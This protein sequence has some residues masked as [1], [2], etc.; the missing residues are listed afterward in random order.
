MAPRPPGAAPGAVA[1]AISGVDGRLDA[2][3]GRWRGRPV[4]DAL[5]YAASALGDHGLVWFLI[6]LA[7]A[8]RPG[9]RRRVA[10]WALVFSG[11]V[12]PAVNTAVKTLVGRGRPDPRDD[13]PRQVRA[14]RTTS[15]PSGHALAA[16]CAATV[17]ADDDPGAPLYYLLAATVSASRIHLRQHHATDV[18][19]GAALGL[20][21]GRWGRRLGHR[22]TGT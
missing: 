22:L 7:R 8:R 13:D 9:R 17:L 15:F 1:E 3:L 20:G 6:G 4:P 11:A 21:L 16:W 5:A 19:A 10:V 18:L 12:T 14:A 2:V